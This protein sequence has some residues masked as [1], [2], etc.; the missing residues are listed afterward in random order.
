M[1]G[2]SLIIYSG[3]AHLSMPKEHFPMVRHQGLG[4]WCLGVHAVPPG[5]QLAP[6][7]PSKHEQVLSEHSK[8]SKVAVFLMKPVPKVEQTLKRFA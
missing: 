3:G 6:Q 5:H 4:L 2:S 1:R 7:A 8:P